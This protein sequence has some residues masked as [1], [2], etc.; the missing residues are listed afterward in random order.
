LIICIRRRVHIGIERWGLQGPLWVISS[1]SAFTWARSALPLEADMH[2]LTSARPLCATSAHV[3]FSRSRLKTGPAAPLTLHFLVA[4]FEKTLAFA[5][6][7]FLFPFACVLLHVLSKSNTNAYNQAGENT[8]RQIACG[9][10]A[11]FRFR[12]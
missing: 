8:I 7:A 12:A 4:L 3:A 9:R 1:P 6:L 5:I 11:N 10:W 2:E